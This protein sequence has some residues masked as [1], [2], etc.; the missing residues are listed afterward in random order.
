VPHGAKVLLFSFTVK[1]K[2]S[3]DKCY[4]VDQVLGSGGFGTV[5]A[6]SRRRDGKLVSFVSS[7][8]PKKL[9]IFLTCCLQVLQDIVSI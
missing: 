5:Y 9:G 7:K 3:F 2:E 6:G 8:T 4:A 1:E